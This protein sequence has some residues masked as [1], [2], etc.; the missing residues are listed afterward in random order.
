MYIMSHMEM[1]KVIYI[2]Y[3]EIL[4]NMRRT[5]GQRDQIIFLLEFYECIDG[6]FRTVI[7]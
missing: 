1:V 3:C 2:H 6:C 7:N 4:D 5:H